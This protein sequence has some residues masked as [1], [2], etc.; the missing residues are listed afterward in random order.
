[1]KVKLIFWSWLLVPFSL[2]AASGIEKLDSDW[3]SQHLTREQYLVNSMQMIFAPDQLPATYQSATPIKCGTPILLQVKTHWATFAPPVQKAWQRY[4]ERPQ[5]TETY[6]SPSGRFKIHFDRL[7]DDA[8]NPEDLDQD[9]WPDF[10]NAAAAALDYSYALIVDSL[11]YT[12]PPDDNDLDGPEYDLFFVNINAYGQTQPEDIISQAPLRYTSY[13]TINHKF[14]LGFATHGL[15]AVRV[16]CAHE[17]FHM[18]QLGY[19]YRESDL[20]FYEISST[21]MEDVAYDDVN[22]YYAYLNPFFRNPAV[23]FNIYNGSHE[24]GACLWNHLLEKKYGATMI[25]K[26]WQMMRRFPVLEASDYVLIDHGS[27]LKTELENF[28]IWNFFTGSRSDPVQ[29]YPEGEYYPEVTYRKTYQF[30]TD[31]ALTDSINKFSG[32]YYFFKDPGQSRNFA[33]ILQH[34]APGK[35]WQDMARYQLDILKYPLNN[36]HKPIDNQLYAGFNAPNL[37]DWCANVALIRNDQS[38]QVTSLQATTPHPV[39]A[40]RLFPNP[41]FIGDD[42]EL[43]IQFELT[44][45]EWVEISILSMNGDIIKRIKIEG[46]LPGFLSSGFRPE[47]AWDGTNDAGELVSSGVY[48]VCLKTDNFVKIDKVSVI[49]Q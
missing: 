42:P 46:I 45:R 40:L 44:Q 8:I 36:S 33:I 11:G 15:D 35:D 24:Y 49:R 31:I 28:S 7:G 43:K 39:S 22:D 10:V 21:W 34:L 5:L 20:F 13:M 12:A 37:S 2:L 30:N 17:F 14:G 47:G 9:G 19:V 32:V 18:V 1:M 3:W 6:L 48:L 26:I 27:N 38:I 4:V 41:F 16:T 25:L 29:Y 23:A